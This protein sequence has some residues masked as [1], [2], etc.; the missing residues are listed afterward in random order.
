[1]ELT[2]QDDGATICIADPGEPTTGTRRLSITK[3]EGALLA[4]LATGMRVLE[5]GTGLGVSTQFLAS[6]ARFVVT[7]DPDP[8]VREHVWR[9]LPAICHP[10][11]SRDDISREFDLVFI[12]A[13]HET[14]PTI[15]DIDFAH[16]KCL[17]GMIVVH[18]AKMATVRRALESFGSFGIVDT[19]FGM[20][21]EFVG[22]TP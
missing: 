19:H 15:A 4:R 3:E 13:D 12:D 10:R 2:V 11:A 18:D 5:I 22:W 6:T 20:G 21:V 9:D 17:R 8:W 16:D 1:M 7:I 14:D